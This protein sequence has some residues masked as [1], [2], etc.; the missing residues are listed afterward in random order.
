MLTLVW[1][2][3]IMATI[4]VPPLEACMLNKMALPTA[5]R[6]TAKTSSSRGWLVMGASMGQM[7]SSPHVAQDRSRLV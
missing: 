6:A 1:R 3:R 7:N 2:L 5:G 4:S